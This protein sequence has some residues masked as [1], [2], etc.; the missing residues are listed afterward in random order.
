[1]EIVIEFTAS[2]CCRIWSKCFLNNRNIGAKLIGWQEDTNWQ[3]LLGIQ[4]K[5]IIVNSTGKCVVWKMELNTKKIMYFFGVD[6]KAVPYY[7]LYQ[8]KS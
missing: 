7:K 4:S 2:K 8:C 3:D 5:I 6:V 1:M